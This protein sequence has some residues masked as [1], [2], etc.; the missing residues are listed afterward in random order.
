MPPR[1]TAKQRAK[2]IDPHVLR[3][4]RWL[5]RGRIWL[6][7]AAALLAIGWWGAGIVARRADAWASPGP[8]AAVH[9]KWANDC[10]KCHTRFEAIRSDA[11]L[12]SSDARSTADQK[13]QLCHRVAL[14]HADPLGRFGHHALPDDVAQN[15]SCATCHHEHQGA[16]ARL[17]RAS[18]R[19]CTICHNRE[20]LV[21]LVVTPADHADALSFGDLKRVTQFSADGHPDFRSLQK[22]AERKLKFGAKS[23]QFHMSLTV[24]QLNAASR[25]KYGQGKSPSDAVKLGCSDCHQSD[26]RPSAASEP[27]GAL[28]APVM[29]EQHCQQCH[30]LTIGPGAADT[31]AHRLTAVQLA[32]EVRK[33][34]E[35]RYLKDHPEA[36]ARALPLP[37]H[38]VESVDAAASEWIQTHSDESAAHLN[39]VCSECHRFAQDRSAPTTNATPFTTAALPEVARP[40]VQAPLLLHAKFDHAAHR[41]WDCRECHVAAYPSAGSLG[42]PIPDEPSSSPLAIAGR[43]KCLECHS[44]RRETATGG[45]GGAQFDCA[46][47][48][49]YHARRNLAPIQEPSRQRGQSHF[50]PQTPQ[51]WDSP[52]R[53]SDRLLAAT[54]PTQ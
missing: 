10:E 51:N 24:G 49:R 15:L 17:T 19:D 33:H 47:C 13:C 18:D 32:V 16:A 54:P 29:F 20:D 22:P 11:A 36:T 53:S 42:L 27:A 52:R 40:L 38:P 28:M 48:H 14:D 1:E 30:P 4:R 21:K 31:V 3:G 5:E 43:D 39:R 45:E 7:I 34:W 2:R 50:A 44:P 6:A 9:A 12:A 35:D 26:N 46:E 8:V 23:H 25:Q 41:T 37:S